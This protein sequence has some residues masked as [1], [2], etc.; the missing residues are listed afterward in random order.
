MDNK[1]FF[2]VWFFVLILSS[3]IHLS[4][5]LCQWPAL[6]HRAHSECLIERTS[7]EE[8]VTALSWRCSS[9]LCVDFPMQ[10]LIDL[11]FAG[12]PG[13]PLSILRGREKNDLEK[14]KNKK[15]KPRN[16]CSWSCAR[17]KVNVKV[18]FSSQESCWE[19]CVLGALGNPFSP[20]LV[21]I[22]PE[23]QPPWM[24]LSHNGVMRCPL[25]P[26]L[27]ALTQAKLAWQLGPQVQTPIWLSLSSLFWMKC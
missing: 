18:T 11:M 21:Q 23:A 1:P 26:Q 3:C 9:D 12:P 7:R 2:L 25:T 5:D 8:L 20:D 13:E 27:V 17:H 10:T 4:V 24:R 6:V 19:R 22:P 14:T 15:T 16:V